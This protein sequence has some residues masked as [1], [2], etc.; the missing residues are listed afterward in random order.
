[1]FAVT[2]DQPGGPEQM[3]WEE[4]PDPHPQLGEVVVDI[5]A[6][7]VNRADVLQRQGFYPPPEEA[8]PILGLEC[9]G[10]VSEL[11]TG[12]HSVRVGDRV[13]ALLTGGG[14]AEKVA[15]PIGQVM[16]LPYGMDLTTS[17]SVPE[18]AATAWSNLVN[19]GELQLGET[20]LIH[21]GAGGVGSHAIQLAKALGAT[22]ATTAGSP[23]KL[24]LCA[25]L[26]ADILINYR[27]QDFAE[28][29]RY[30]TGGSGADVIL[31][32]MGAKYL[33]KNLQALAHG[34]RLVIIGMQGGVK[35]ELDITKLMAK[36]TSIQATTL[37]RRPQEQKAE[38]CAALVGIVWPMFGV[39]RIKSV[40]DSTMPITHVVAAH[41]RLESGD[42]TGKIILTVREAA[43]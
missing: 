4:V 22:V 15:V 37:R 41:Q 1:M 8:S 32:N 23:E 35:G 29:L 34:G 14:Y 10:V 31:D 3:Q 36:R 9:S 5:T 43:E 13:C 21:G 42:A 20:V 40:I 25:Q 19:V 16:P 11:G 33:D 38:I 26:G 39:G 24:E 2:V 7:A 12:V 17:A 27:E 18:V 28:V 6:T 30:S